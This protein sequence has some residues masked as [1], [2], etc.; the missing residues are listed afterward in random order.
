[1]QCTIELPQRQWIEVDQMAV[2]AGSEA[3]KSEWD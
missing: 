2:N 3:E 1:M